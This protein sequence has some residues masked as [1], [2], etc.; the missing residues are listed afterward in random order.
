MSEQAMDGDS[1]DEPGRRSRRALLAGAAGAL[2]VIAAETVIKAAPAQAG[3]DGDVVLGADNPAPG[4]TTLDTTGVGS[5]GALGALSNTTTGVQPA[6]F[7]GNDGSGPGV[8]SFSY[9]GGEG[10][11]AQSGTLEGTNKGVTSTGAHGVSDASFGSGVWGENVGGGYGVSGNTTSTGI[12][13]KPAVNGTNGGSGPGVYGTSN[14]GAALYGLNTSGTEGVYAQSGVTT[15]TTPGATRTGIHGV[16]N[17]SDAGAVWGENLGGGDGVKGTSG[18]GSGLHG[19]ASALT[20]IGVLAENTGGGTALK[21]SGP[22]IFSRSG[23]VVIP[24]GATKA[25]VTPP[26]GLSSA[27]LVLAVMQ[28]VAGSV[29]VKAVVPNPGAGT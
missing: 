9:G 16:T 7:V 12:G 6:A 11:Y 19:Q 26:G 23:T 25:T 28:N 13:G 14:G 29:M 22:S 27:A 8:T 2:G 15:G 21:V 1:S 5:V 3:T 18:S 4:F 17:S 24:S 20:G 10:I